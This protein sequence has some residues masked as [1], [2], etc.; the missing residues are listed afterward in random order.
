MPEGGLLSQ[1]P[2][3]PGTLTHT[4]THF[5]FQNSHLLPLITMPQSHEL[6]SIS[7]ACTPHPDVGSLVSHLP[8]GFSS[9][10]SD[11]S[12][13]PTVQTLSHILPGPTRVLHQCP[14]QQIRFCAPLSISLP[15]RYCDHLEGPTM[16]PYDRL[17]NW[18]PKTLSSLLTQKRG[19]THQSQT[20]VTNTHTSNIYNDNMEYFLLST[21]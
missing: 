17:N 7:P 4:H 14:S 8:S 19:N 12:L 1:D 21:P 18:S 16:M 15:Y 10:L 6:P 11:L 3:A 2:Q 13:Q 20:T 9:H 5:L